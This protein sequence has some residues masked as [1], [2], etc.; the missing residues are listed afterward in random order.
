MNAPLSS[1]H[2]ALLDGSAEE[3]R[4]PKTPPRVARPSEPPQG[5]RWWFAFDRWLVV[6]DADEE[7]VLA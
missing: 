6:A 3:R 5:G 1:A 2:S 7:F 4:T